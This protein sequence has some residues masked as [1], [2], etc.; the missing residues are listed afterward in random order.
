MFVDKLAGRL[1]R[2]TVVSEL[3]LDTVQSGTKRNVD[4][5]RSQR[6]RLVAGKIRPQSVG[7]VHHS[8]TAAVGDATLRAVDQIRLPNG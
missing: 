7:R 5:G 3:G 2:Q 4:R 1:P 8:G 6:S